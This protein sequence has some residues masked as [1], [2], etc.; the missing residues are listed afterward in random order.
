MS[1]KRTLI[2]SFFDIY[3]KEHTFDSIKLLIDNFMANFSLNG[4]KKF[5]RG[6]TTVQNIARSKKASIDAFRLN[7]HYM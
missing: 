6:S 3:G 7:T 5:G 4:Y 1:D 2:K